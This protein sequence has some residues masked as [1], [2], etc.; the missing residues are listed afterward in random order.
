MIYWLFRL[1]LC[2]RVSYYFPKTELPS[3]ATIVPDS[4][5]KRLPRSRND[6]ARMGSGVKLHWE[7]H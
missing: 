4:A 6:K 2:A 3:L 1:E 5:F 7:G